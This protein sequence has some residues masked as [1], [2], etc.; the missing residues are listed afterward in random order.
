MRSPHPWIYL[1]P[2]TIEIDYRKCMVPLNCRRCLSVC[3]QAVFVIDPPKAVDCQ[4]V[5]T[6][7]PEAHKLKARFRDRCTACDECVRVCPV[8]ALK[9]H[10]LGA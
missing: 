4:E 6:Q 7:E 5:S 9:V 1:K 10:V 2:P 3:P 8:D